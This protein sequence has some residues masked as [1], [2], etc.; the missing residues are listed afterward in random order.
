MLVPA[1]HP[2]GEPKRRWSRFGPLASLALLICSSLLAPQPHSRATA[3]QATAELQPQPSNMGPICLP[4]MA[5][6]P[7]HQFELKL[8]SVE[9]AK[10]PLTN[11]DNGAGEPPHLQHRPHQQL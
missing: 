10:R 3:Y 7:L 9:M 8:N 1:Y 6:R 5:K 2:I 4:K 11:P